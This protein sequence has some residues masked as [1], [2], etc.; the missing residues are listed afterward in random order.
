MT[1]SE[2][3]QGNQNGAR[4][5]INAVFPLDDG[6][7]LH[8]ELPEDLSPREADRF[9]LMLRAW[10]IEHG[11]VDLDATTDTAS[12]PI[13]GL[14][15]S[16][17]LEQILTWLTG[18][19]LTEPGGVKEQARAE[20]YSYIYTEVLELIPE[21]PWTNKVLGDE[22]MPKG[23]YRDLK[24]K[25]EGYNRAISDMRARAATKWGKA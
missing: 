7:I 17:R 25:Q 1:D 21:N 22:E 12:L 4:S 20:I 6:T 11:A 2:V 9:G 8:I 3:P 14:P 15:H 23:K 18:N 16:D 10:G 13:P 5:L 19:S 24:R